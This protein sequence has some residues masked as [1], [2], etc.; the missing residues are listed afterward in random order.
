MSQGEHF[1]EETSMADWE[2]NPHIWAL[3]IQGAETQWIKSRERNLT[4]K[5]VNHFG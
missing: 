1:F 3:A 5:H 4:W 2:I